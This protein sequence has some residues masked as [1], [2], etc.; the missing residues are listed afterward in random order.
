[1]L[2]L[3]RKENS[4]DKNQNYIK[5]AKD[6]ETELNCRAV[7]N[8]QDLTTLPDRKLFFENAICLAK[9]ATDT[10]KYVVSFSSGIWQKIIGSKFFDAKIYLAD[11]SNSQMTH[12]P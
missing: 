5:Q 12:R 8:V 6:S 9:S 4:L 1:M 3:I 2:T 11:R 10:I 7:Y